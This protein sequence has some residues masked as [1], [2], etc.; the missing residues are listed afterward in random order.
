MFPRLEL[1]T[2]FQVHTKGK[3]KLIVLYSLIFTFPG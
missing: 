2:N 1:Q 3:D